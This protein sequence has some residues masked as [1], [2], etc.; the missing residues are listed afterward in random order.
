MFLNG[1]MLIF[2]KKKTCAIRLQLHDAKIIAVVCTGRSVFLYRNFEN[3]RQHLVLVTLV[4]VICVTINIHRPTATASVFACGAD[5][6][7]FWKVIGSADVFHID[8][9]SSR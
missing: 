7:E 8:L 9:T 6:T 4:V 5:A 3:W 1:A 2:F